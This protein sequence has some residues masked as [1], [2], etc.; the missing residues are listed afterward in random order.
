MNWSITPSWVPFWRYTGKKSERRKSVP[1]KYV[2]VKKGHEEKWL[3]P[4]MVE[5]NKALL[6]YKKIWGLHIAVMNEEIAKSEKLIC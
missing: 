6:P 5:L 1:L 2:L 3:A 4:I